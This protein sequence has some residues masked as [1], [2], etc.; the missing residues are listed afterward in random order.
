M[1]GRQAG[2]RPLA[3]PKEQKDGA[4]ILQRRLIAE[5]HSNGPS[6]S[7]TWRPAVCS[8]KNPD[9]FRVSD[10][11]AE[12]QREQIEALTGFRSDRVPLLAA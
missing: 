1:N 12:T 3:G 7:A 8:F 4:V 5:D 9:G 2:K 10:G 6:R 11:T